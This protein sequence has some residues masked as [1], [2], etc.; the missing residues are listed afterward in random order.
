MAAE[1]HIHLS[2]KGTRVIIKVFLEKLADAH[3]RL[4]PLQGPMDWHRVAKLDCIQH[5]LLGE[6][7]L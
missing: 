5:A 4:R 2:Q 3:Y 1:E 7:L 6:F